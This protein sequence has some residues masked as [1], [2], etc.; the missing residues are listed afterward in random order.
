V[1][2]SVFGPCVNGAEADDVGGHA[3][4]RDETPVVIV[5][6]DGRPGDGP[7]GTADAVALWREDGFTPDVIDI[8]K[9]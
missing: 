3:V 1:P 5:V 9:L 2:Y 6:W 8:T 7:G 4:A